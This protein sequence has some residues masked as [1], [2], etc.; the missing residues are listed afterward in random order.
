MS[1]EARNPE[2][3]RM[4]EAEPKASSAAVP[5]VIFFVLMAVL[6]A[7]TLYLD[8]YS[9]GFNPLVYSPNIDAPKPPDDID[10]KGKIVYSQACM[11]CHQA[12]GQGMAGQFPPLAGSEWVLTANPERMIRIVLNGASGPMTAKGAQYNNVMVPWR[13]VLKDEDIAAVVTYVRNEWGNKASAVTAQQVKAVRD[14]T[15]D[16]SGP[17]TEPELLQVPEQ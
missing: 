13:D 7:G 12:N 3:R 9:G 8:R 6:Y 5:I 11:P 1:A 14:A 10:P 2:K 15:A 16:K 17:W 4:E